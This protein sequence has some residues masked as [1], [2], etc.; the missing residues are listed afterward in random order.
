MNTKKRVMNDLYAFYL[1]FV[2]KLF[3]NEVI[4]AP[5]V[6]KICVE[7]MKMYLGDYQKLSVSL[8]PRHKL[9]DSTP[10]LTANRGWITHGDLNIGDY[11]FGPDG[12]PTKIIGVSEKSPC[13]KLVSFSNGSKIL[14]HSGHLWS[15][16]KRGSSKL[17]TLSTSEIEDN[18][19]Y[20]ENNGKKRYRYHL[21]LIE[22]IQYEE[23][24]LPID[25]YWLGYWLGDGSYNKPCI[26]HSKEDSNFIDA[27]PYKVSSQA[28]HKDTGVYTTYFSNQGLI[29]KIRTLNLYEN[30]HI[31]DIYKNSSFEQRIQLLAGLI[32]SDGSVD[33]NG[34]VR[35]INT[36][37]QLIDDVYELCVGLGLY[38]Y[39]MKPIAPEKI[40]KYKENS[41]SLQ[42]TSKK[43][44][45]TIGFQPRFTI[46]TQ[47]PRKNIVKKGLRRKLAITNIETVSSEMGK[48]IEIE[49][50]D[51]IYLAGKELIPTHNSKSSLIT[52]AFP[53]WLI[54]RDP[55]LN[56]MV[57]T[58]T[59]NLSESFGIRIRELFLQ[60]QDI[61]PVRIS[62]KKHASG[63]IM[64]E[65]KEG[66]LT[67]GS[68]R[69][70]GLGGQITG[71]DAD[72]VI[73]DD[74]VKGIQ[75][76]TPTQLQKTKDFFDGVLLQRLEPHSKLIVL[77]TLWSSEDILSVIRKER[78]DEYHILDLPAYNEK[79]EILWPEKYNLDYF[80]EKENEM[81]NRLFQ[82][83]Y[84]CRPL[85]ET[86]AFFKLDNLL[87][88]T[89]KFHHNSICV[90]SWDL[91]YS[92]ESKGDINDYSA[93]IKMWKSPEGLYWI[94]DLKN[95]QYGENIHN[96][97]KRTAYLDTANVP[98]LIETGTKGGAS[99]FYYNDLKNIYLKGYN[100]KQS[101]PIGSKVD[102]AL[103]FR[104]A[105]WDGKVVID[106]D[107]N[108]R[109]ALIK[110]LNSFPLGK[111]DDIIDACSYAYNY[112][113][114]KKP[115]VKK[116]QASKKQRVK[117]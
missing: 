77:G 80:H 108:G 78:S 65:D 56:I 35:F 90:R 32:D 48:C 99:K 64:F 36:N 14:A 27:V 89:F 44:S 54:I 68:I 7:L 57:V 11:V 66:N 26:T 63:W 52:L 62:N 73:V 43:T 45:Y 87:F 114:D 70:V 72:W 67:G 24:D 91:A 12:K 33:K 106:L 95:G 42:I 69:L 115:I 58:S 25:S 37:K 60:Y 23:A 100:V 47:I 109:E 30:K 85:D 75:D 3:N 112:L 17:Q 49:N 113:Q 19:Y 20:I 103:T 50:A 1:N 55:T 15:V 110:Q 111:H 18:Y 6:K 81:G 88:D 94:T 51:G 84:M 8:P 10:I 104:D 83:L 93:S 76:C 28:I 97:L 2:V 59:F 38:P 107:E 86:G 29:K 92:D 13:N 74:I 39:K 53:L 40:N 9:G 61:L 116:L 101:E 102:R 79:D 117:L 34:R 46:P 16:Y 22:P 105:I 5:H 71:F 82:A 4:P 41:D 31:P 98:I 96:E 21:P